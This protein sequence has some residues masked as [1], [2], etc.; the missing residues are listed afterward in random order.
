MLTYTGNDVTYIREMARELAE[1]AASAENAAVLRRW[2]DVNALRTPDRAPVWC[3]PAD[4]WKELL[5]PESL[6]C[7]DS[8]LR[9]VEYTLRQ[10]LIKHEIGDDTP[11]FGDFS[12]NAVF[13]WKPPNA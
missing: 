11:F 12:V 3:R 1:I 8:W 13:Q 5:P 2:R 9:G 6:H 10:D 7:T 4:A